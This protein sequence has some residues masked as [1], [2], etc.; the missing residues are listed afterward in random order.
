MASVKTL[1]SKAE[2]LGRGAALFIS[3]NAGALLPGRLACRCLVLPPGCR[4]SAGGAGPRG[5]P[6]AGP[7]P[8]SL[9]DQLPH[10]Q[11]QGHPAA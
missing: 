10:V 8:P 4:G 6:I 2:V 7:P 11:H 9:H 5:S 3:I 1:N